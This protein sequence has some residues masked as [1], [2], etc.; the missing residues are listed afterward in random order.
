[1]L[2]SMS[3]SCQECPQ[4][5]EDLPRQTLYLLSMVFLLIAAAIACAVAYARS[6]KGKLDFQQLADTF[7]ILG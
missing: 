3:D 5:F 1:M 4:S 2:M 6:E 7:K